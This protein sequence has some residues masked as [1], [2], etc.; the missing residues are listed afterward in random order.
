[1]KTHC[2]IAIRR[3]VYRSNLIYKPTT[4][5]VVRRQIWLVNVSLFIITYTS[6]YVSLATAVIYQKKKKKEHKHWRVTLLFLAICFVHTHTHF[7]TRVNWKTRERERH[8][9]ILNRPQYFFPCSSFRRENAC[10]YHRAVHL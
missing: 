6:A 7:Y 2:F 8:T 3:R 4:A 5:V 1:M 9:F 10:H